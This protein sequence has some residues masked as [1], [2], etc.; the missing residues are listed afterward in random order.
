MILATL[1]AGVVILLGNLAVASHLPFAADLRG[2]ARLTELEGSPAHCWR[3]VH[4][5]AAGCGCSNKVAQHL[6]AR[7]PIAGLHESV[8][9]V[10]SDPRIGDLLR[11]SRLALQIITAVEAEERYHLDGAPWLV[12]I[13]P[14]D[15]IRYAGGYSRDRNAADGYQDAAIWNAV[16]SGRSFGSLP[17]FGCAVS[18]RLRTTIDPLGLKYQSTTGS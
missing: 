8:L 15:S 7:G 1:S 3:A 14:D 17:A 12:M 10:G 18:H 6:V 9:L 4:I 16:S 2:F 5:L 11:G 13:D